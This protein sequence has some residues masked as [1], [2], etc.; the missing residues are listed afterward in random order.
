MFFLHSHIILF[1]TT[2]WLL[3][4]YLLYLWWCYHLLLSWYWYI[5]R[6]RLTLHM[7]AMCNCWLACS[8]T[9]S[10]TLHCL[11]SGQ[12]H[13]Q[14]FVQ[15]LKTQDLPKR[16]IPSNVIANQSYRETQLFVSWVY[17]Q[18]KRENIVLF[19][20]FFYNALI[21]LTWKSHNLLLSTGKQHLQNSAPQRTDGELRHINE[22]L[23]H[24]EGSSMRGIQESVQTCEIWLFMQTQ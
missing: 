24:F 15:L 17:L 18:I 8:D 21:F 11:M 10:K 3:S 4:V 20:S 1:C 6:E 19:F 9:L 23:Q 14:P 5:L 13:E 2:I 12:I 22:W 7:P 16:L